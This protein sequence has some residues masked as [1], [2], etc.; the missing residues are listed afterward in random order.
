M[1]AF[2]MLWPLDM[3]RAERGKGREEEGMHT[4]SGVRLTEAVTAHSLLA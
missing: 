2:T 4:S 1:T 3:P